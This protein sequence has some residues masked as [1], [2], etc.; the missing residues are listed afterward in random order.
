M[1]KR[2]RLC[3]QVAEMG[4]LRMLAGLSL[5]DRVRSSAI[6]E[7][8]GV[9]LLLLC[10]ESS[11]LRWFGH[12]VRMVRASG[13]LP[14][15]EFQAS[16]AGRRPCGRPRTRW[17]DYI[18]TL[19]WERIGILQSALVNMSR[20]REVLGSPARAFSTDFFLSKVSAYTM[21]ALFDWDI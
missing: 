2:T 10:I 20:E 19:A 11:Q 7:E 3:V 21:S 9:E 13:C 4:F 14:R 15:E 12:L 18:S 1:T 17:R 8:L 5:G 6:C 16:S